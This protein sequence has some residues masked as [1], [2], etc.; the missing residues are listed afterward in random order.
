MYKI[1]HIPTGL[2][3]R[4]EFILTMSKGY[5]VY[6]FNPKNFLSHKEDAAFFFKWSAFFRLWRQV[7]KNKRNEYELVRLNETFE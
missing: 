7:P 1:L 3:V 6:Y 2:F 5:R 4:S